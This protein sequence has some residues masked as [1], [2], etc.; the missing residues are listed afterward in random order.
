[1]RNKIFKA[2]FIRQSFTITCFVNFELALLEK[3]YLVYKNNIQTCV[4]CSMTYSA[5]ISIKLLSK[6]QINIYTTAKL[7]SVE[8]FKCGEECKFRL[9]YVKF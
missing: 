1:M 5:C 7:L 9:N 4:E 8:S 6:M 3:S 2:F